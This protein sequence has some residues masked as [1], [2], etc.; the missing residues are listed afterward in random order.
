MFTSSQTVPEML[1]SLKF[2]KSTK[3]RDAGWKGCKP[4]WI[5]PAWRTSLNGT[6]TKFEVRAAET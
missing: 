2:R 4:V 1:M 3:N 6:G 5:H